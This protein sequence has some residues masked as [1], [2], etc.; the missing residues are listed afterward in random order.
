MGESIAA[1]LRQL[2]DSKLGD[3]LPSWSEHVHRS[4]VSWI[5]PTIHSLKK[6]GLFLAKVGNDLVL[7]LGVLLGVSL[8]NPQVPE[9]ERYRQIGRGCL[10]KM[11]RTSPILVEKII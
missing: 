3:L 9:K 8:T 5:R 7:A 11:E 4:V 1:S 2:L 10:K 6:M